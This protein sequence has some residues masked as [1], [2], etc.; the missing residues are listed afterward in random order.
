MTVGRPVAGTSVTIAADGEILI[1]MPHR[2]AIGYFGVDQAEEAAVFL[3]N[4]R[5]ATG[6]LGAFDRDGYLS[7]T[8]R[9]KNLILRQ[10]GEKVSVEA[11][12]AKLAAV[13]GA[14]RAVVIGGG[15]LPWLGAIVGIDPTCDAA[16]EARVRHSVEATIEAY[17]RNAKA[18]ARIDRTLVT[19]VPF[20]A[21]SGLLTR[22]LKLDR[23]AIHRRFKPDLLAAEPVASK[24]CAA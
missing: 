3:P 8:G 12:E 11:V 9:K 10:S 7:I 1:D 24:E 19:R 15:D 6:D 23:T 2:Q 22:N 16:A 14:E 5:I 20:T 21:E 18:N 4:G 17:N 13:P